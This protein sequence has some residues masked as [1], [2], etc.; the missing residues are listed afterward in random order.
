MHVNCN[1]YGGMPLTLYRTP[2]EVKGDIS[3]IKEKI[4]EINERM[5]MRTLLMDVLSDEKT[6]ANPDFW[7]PELTEALAVVLESQLKLIALEEELTEL[8][9]ELRQTRWI[10]GN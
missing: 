9:E 6:V 1:T 7:I 2:S 8:Y 5:N 10:R 3:A 4:K